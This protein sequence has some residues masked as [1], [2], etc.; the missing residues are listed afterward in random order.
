M[1]IDYGSHPMENGQLPNRNPETGIRY[2]IASMHDLADWLFD[3]F[4]AEYAHNCPECGADLPEDF[5]SPK[6]CPECRCD[7]ADGEDWGDEPIGHHL[8][9]DGVTASLSGSGEVWVFK[10]PVGVFGRHCS[11]CAPGAVSIGPKNDGDVRAYG[12]PADWWRDED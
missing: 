6:Q 7:I 4:E 1:T 12:L 10:S 8:E 11:P 3:E 2:G 9:T 5:L